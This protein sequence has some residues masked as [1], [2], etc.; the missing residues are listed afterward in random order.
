MVQITSPAKSFRGF[1]DRFLVLHPEFESL[2][3]LNQLTQDWI[4]N[5]YNN[6][7]HSAIQMT[8]LQRFNL[9]HNRVTYLMHDDITDIEQSRKVSKVNVLSINNQKLEC[10]VDLRRKTVQIRYDCHRRDRFIVY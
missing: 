2:A 10:P 9:D 3:Q 6:H 4:E 8:P 7:L 1:R 5:D